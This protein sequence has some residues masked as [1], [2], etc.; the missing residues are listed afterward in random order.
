[1]TTM[2]DVVICE[3]LRTPVGGYLGGLAGLSAANLATVVVRE[4]A[5]RANLGDGDVNDVILGNC[6]PSGDFP[7]LGRVVALDAGLGVGVPAC[8]STVGADRACRPR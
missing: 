3:P 7:A 6:N 5:R 2:R 4:I 8:R 1:M